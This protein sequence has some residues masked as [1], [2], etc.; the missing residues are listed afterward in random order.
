MAVDQG[1]ADD[2]RARGLGRR[3]HGGE[4]KVVQGLDGWLI[5]LL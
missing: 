2:Q 4:L 1:Q 3:D 5:Y